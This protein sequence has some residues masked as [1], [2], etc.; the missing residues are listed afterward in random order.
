MAAA[1]LLLLLEREKPLL[2][3]QEHG[4]L[5]RSESNVS[6]KVRI[7]CLLHANISPAAGHAVPGMPA[8]ANMPYFATESISMMAHCPGCMRV[9]LACPSAD[10]HASLLNCAFNALSLS[11]GSSLYMTGTTAG[12]AAG[13]TS[14]WWS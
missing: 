9:L 2:Q 6:L 11:A 12:A 14:M 13:H 10:T 7:Q 3:A 8:A 1:P 4:S 5:S